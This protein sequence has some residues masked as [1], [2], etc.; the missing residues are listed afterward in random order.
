M[1]APPRPCQ[2]WHLPLM[3]LLV[4]CCLAVPG[5]AAAHSHRHW[6]PT[7]RA[8]QAINRTAV[9]AT[10]TTRPAQQPARRSTGGCGTKPPSPEL[11]QHIRDRIAAAN[12]AAVKPA[13]AAAGRVGIAAAAQSG[14]QR[15]SSI[16]IGLVFHVISDPN[17]QV[18]ADL[19][20]NSAVD[21][22]EIFY[23]APHRAANPGDLPTCAH[24]TGELLSTY[25]RLA[26]DMF[27]TVCTSAT[28]ERN[29]GIT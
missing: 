20:G 28:R 10:S 7:G 14:L 25:I 26:S 21:A 9:A 23:T 16:T 13:A 2:L 19:N 8:L 11:K 15:A 29:C 12:A 6:S 17:V 24:L 3:L 22:G 4:M 18:H 27:C 5:P 1:P